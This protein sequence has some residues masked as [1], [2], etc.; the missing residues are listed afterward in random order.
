MSQLQG[1]KKTQSWT[2]QKAITMS[3]LIIK[4]ILI[5]QV[6]ATSD[7]QMLYFQIE[8]IKG[9]IYIYLHIQYEILIIFITHEIFLIKK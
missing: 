3:R 6:S 7:I 8:T 9:V 5:G 1:N 4:Y 2:K